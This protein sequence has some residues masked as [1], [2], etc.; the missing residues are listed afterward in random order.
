MPEKQA[1]FQVTEKPNNRK[2]LYSVA[3]VKETLDFSAIEEQLRKLSDDLKILEW[4]LDRI[5]AP[6]RKKK[7]LELAREDGGFHTFK[8]YKGRV[9]P[10]IKERDLSELYRDGKLLRKSSGSHIVF[11]L[12]ENDGGS[13]P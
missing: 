3:K 9:W 12:P 6:D 11:G 7:I 1:W 8:W 10:T 2:F 4:R 5:E 13:S